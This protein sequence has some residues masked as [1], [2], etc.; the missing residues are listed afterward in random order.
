MTSMREYLRIEVRS[1]AMQGKGEGETWSE[2]RGRME[3]NRKC[4][5]GDSTGMSETG[6]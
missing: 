6:I 1:E 5:K 3:Q 4:L 2:A